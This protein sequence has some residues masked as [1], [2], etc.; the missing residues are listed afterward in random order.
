MDMKEMFENAQ[1]KMI[2]KRMN[3]FLKQHIIYFSLMFI[4]VNP[5][6]EGD[7]ADGYAH[8]S[9][10][11]AEE[12]Q[13]THQS[14]EKI[15]DYYKLGKMYLMQGDFTSSYNA[16]LKGEKLDGLGSL[17]SE[18]FI[19]PRQTFEDTSVL[20]KT[21]GVEKNTL[22]SY[23][24]G[25]ID[26]YVQRA[27]ALINDKSD[28]DEAR[29]E[30]NK[31]FI[32]DATNQRARELERKLTSA[33]AEKKQRKTARSEKAHKEREVIVRPV[34]P[35]ERT[36]VLNMTDQIS[37]QN[38]AK[39]AVATDVIENALIQAERQMSTTLL[40][41]PAHETA[42]LRLKEH[43]D[44]AKKY[45]QD[46]EFFRAVAEFKK[47][48]ALNSEHMYAVYAREYIRK[49][50]QELK[51]Q[52]ER[53]LHTLLRQEAI[54]FDASAR[55]STHTG[56]DSLST[57][58]APGVPVLNEA[59]VSDEAKNIKKSAIQ[60]RTDEVLTAQE[61]QNNILKI[62]AEERVRR[63]EAMREVWRR[64]QKDRLE[65]KYRAWK[66]LNQSIGKRELNAK[67]KETLFNV[68][69]ALSLK[70]YVGADKALHLLFMLS[71][72]HPEGQKLQTTIQKE[73]E[74]LTHLLK[75]NPEP[76]EVD[77]FFKEE[78]LDQNVGLTKTK[79][80]RRAPIRIELPQAEKKALADSTG[81]PRAMEQNAGG[82][83]MDTQMFAGISQY[84]PFTVLAP[85]G[86]TSAGAQQEGSLG[87][88]EREVVIQ[89][90]RPSVQ[91]KVRFNKDVSQEQEKR[92]KQSEVI[93]TPKDEVPEEKPQRVPNT[94]LSKPA[95]EEATRKLPT[96]DTGRDENI[97]KWMYQWTQKE[98]ISDDVRLVEYLNRGKRHFRQKNYPLALV[99]FNKVMS[100]DTNK[101]YI[102]ET[103][104][105]IAKTKQHLYD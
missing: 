62:Q 42:Q 31:V 6:G 43:Y 41:S 95:D 40:K 61:A 69:K 91:K 68:R 60:M 22:D 12:T 57:M 18:Q 2:W 65:K 102:T 53:D 56:S 7:E 26:L 8:L 84:K 29:N 76:Q 105:L 11:Q 10:A 19:S 80:S 104:E 79:T 59:P 75:K 9:S 64:E 1:P 89:K 100:L 67:V 30:L 34:K 98:S 66:K 74:E 17:P 58:E 101:K 78:D 97:D 55:D 103:Q 36:N 44:Q 35:Q 81:Q 51:S 38:K 63:R 16:F 3:S 71:P 4:A 96:K 70:D 87:K 88:K 48:L 92:I 93:V 54:E 72:D 28:L 90:I 83:L 39:S 20:Q 94:A 82:T 13:Y 49:A 14:A 52:E 47:V 99:S 77:A 46:K 33:E 37:G 32:I 73:I 86:K 27:H 21:G 50:M 85:T 45:F 25:L 23:L 24:S 5:M 15:H